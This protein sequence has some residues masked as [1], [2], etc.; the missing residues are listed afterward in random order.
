MLCLVCLIPICEELVFR[1]LMFKRIRER[2]LL[3]KQLY[4]RRLYSGCPR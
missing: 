1:G 2:A 3:C 4:T